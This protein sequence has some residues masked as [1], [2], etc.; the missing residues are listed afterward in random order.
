[1]SILNSTALQTAAILDVFIG[2]DRF[3][4]SNYFSGLIDDVAIWKAGLDAGEIRSLY[5][6]AD[7]PQLNYSAADVQRLWNLYYAGEGQIQ[8]GSRTWKYRDT[9]S[10]S[11]A[12]ADGQLL[13]MGFGTYHLVMNASEGLGVVSASSG[14]VILV[15]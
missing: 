15:Q 13:A 3:R 7:A 2:L 6:L 10:G 8:I 14:T 9:L 12:T 1:M 4:G 5:Q 11:G